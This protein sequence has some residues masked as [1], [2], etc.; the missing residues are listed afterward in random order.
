MD[1]AQRRERII[2]M[3]DE[4]DRPI[5]GSEFAKRLGVSR[6]VVVQDMALLRAANR[7]ILSTNKGYIHFNPGLKK[8]QKRRCIKVCHHTAQIKDE[9]YTIVDAGARVLDV[10][11]EHSIYGSISVDLLIENRQDTDEFVKKIET[12]DTRPLKELTDNVHYHTIEAASEAV[13]DL[14]VS[15]LRKKGY[16][17]EGEDSTNE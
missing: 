2:A 16:L 10:M 9:L 3:L 14:A 11:V 12:G 8:Q 13:L 17:M 5:S 15:N 7:N 4:S 1:A 6:Q